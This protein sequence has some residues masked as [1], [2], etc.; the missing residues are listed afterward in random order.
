MAPIISVNVMVPYTSTMFR[1]INLGDLNTL[2]SGQVTEPT[3][4]SFLRKSISNTSYNFDFF[5]SSKLSTLTIF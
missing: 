4:E 5:A 3:E 2:S 1:G